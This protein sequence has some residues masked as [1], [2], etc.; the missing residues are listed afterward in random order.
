[1][2]KQNQR[3][4]VTKQLLKSGLI[5]LSKTK[6]I[7]KISIME[8]CRESGINRAT[9]YRHYETPRDVLVE[10]E[11]DLFIRAMETVEKP[12]SLEDARRYLEDVCMFMMDNKETLEALILHNSDMLFVN[13]LDNLCGKLFG[14]ISRIHAFRDCDLEGIKILSL[15][16]SGGSYYILRKWLMGELSK[17]PQEIAS[18]AYSL[19][20]ETN[21]HE[22][23]VELNSIS[24]EKD[25]ILQNLRS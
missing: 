1:M 23:I 6:S 21:W 14:E 9:F 10:I 15:Y 5:R 25:R 8:L 4:A 24:S 7:D 2:N 11:E 19:L 13:V 3:I 22:A 18:L 12:D 16:Y 17:T 20:M